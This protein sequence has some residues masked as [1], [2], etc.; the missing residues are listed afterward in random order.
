[1][2]WRPA[3][4]LENTHRYAMYRIW[5]NTPR[6]DRLGRSY[7]G[8]IFFLSSPDL[9][10]LLNA[11]V[12]SCCCPWSHSMTYTTLGRT[13]LDEWSALRR[14][15]YLTTHNIHNKQTSTPPAGFEPTT[16]ARKR[17]HTHALDRAAS[18]TGNKWVTQTITQLRIIVEFVGLIKMCV[19]IT[20]SKVRIRICFLLRISGNKRILHCHC[21]S[22]LLQGMPL[23][24]SQ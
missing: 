1:M 16:P 11:G 2:G 9:F 24:R 7:K 23:G 20:Y 21:I 18:W 4:I 22:T 15:L 12:K 6:T 3:T 19:T 8:D 14:D 5:D 17:P 10:C 13:P